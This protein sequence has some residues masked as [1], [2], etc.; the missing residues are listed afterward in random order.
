MKKFY[1]LCLFIVTTLTMNAQVDVVF[2]VDMNDVA[3]ADGDIV[4]L[5]GDFQ[6]WNPGLDTFDDSDGNGVYAFTYS[7]DAGTPVLFKFVV[8][9]WGTNEFGDN[10][11]VG[12]CTNEEGNRTLTI[13]AD[14]EGTY[15]LPTFI[16]NTCDVS[17]LSVNTNNIAT[18]EGVKFSPNPASDRTL[19]S[20]ENPTNAQHDII[21]T[22][23]TGQTVGVLSNV[24]GNSAELNVADFATGMYFVTFRNEAG[25]QGTEKLIVR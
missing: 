8:N 22:S 14:A 5:G 25:E 21:I 12:D 10:M 13:P 7:L 17:S 9:T 4:T 1:F 23:M 18:I 24:T 15:M 3:L 16:Y 6:G 2:S 11:M 19:I 20:F